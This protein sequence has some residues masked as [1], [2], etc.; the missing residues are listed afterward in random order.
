VSG[1][2]ALGGVALGW[3]LNA[4]TDL[5]RR[6]RDARTRWS[7][8]RRE[9]AVRFLEA[10][11]R[12]W[13]WS[14]NLTNMRLAE[15]T[16]VGLTIEGVSTYQDV[17]AKTAQADRDLRSLD[18]EI[19]LI[20]SDSEKE[21]ARRL[22]EAAWAVGTAYAAYQQVAEGEREARQREFDA[23]NR[24]YTDAREAFL[25]VARKGLLAA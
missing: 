14:N 21:A 2:F 7:D 12:V 1:S 6:R 15:R 17:M 4:L 23:A 10:A 13:M 9:L 19:Q 24:E 5:V 22:R 16:G 18:T 11:E 25:A 8:L 3:G 20:G